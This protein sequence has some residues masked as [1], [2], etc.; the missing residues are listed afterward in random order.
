MLSSIMGLRPKPRAR[1]ANKFAF[2][3]SGPFASRIVVTGAFALTLSS[4]FA[5]TD[6][7][8][9]DKAPALSGN[10]SSLK[11]TVKGMTS[12][13]NEL[14]EYRVIDSDNVIQSRGFIIPLGGPGASF[15]VKSAVPKAKPP[16]RL[17]FYADHDL[18]GKFN[19]KRPDGTAADHSWRLNLDDAVLDDSGTYVISFDHNTSFSD[20]VNPVPPIEFGKPFTLH[21]KAMGAFRAKRVQIRVA[22]AAVGRIVAMYRIPGIQ[23]DDQDV[24]V[25][26]MIESGVPYSVEIYTDDNNA[27]EAP[28]TGARAFNLQATANDSGLELTFD[29]NAPGPQIANP[30]LP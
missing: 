22:D 20:L 7:D 25:P 18:D 4:C 24:S 23:K 17:D 19:L 8:R 26:G 30:S 2:T 27:P 6:L 14:F 15:N 3:P 12:H 13:V 21:L 5:V 10:F 16:F 11:V 9:F 28:P 1:D 29:G